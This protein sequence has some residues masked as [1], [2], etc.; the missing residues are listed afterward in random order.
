MFFFSPL[1]SMA[2]INIAAAVLPAIF[3]LRYIYRKDKI[4]KE[5][6]SLLRGCVISGLFAVAASI[7]L[8]MAGGYLL[9][10]AVEADDPLYLILFAFLVVGAVEEGTK[11]FFLKRRTWNNPN[12]DYVFDA[13]VYAAFVSLGFAA[14]EN[15]SYV[16]T[17]GISVAFSRAIFSIPG[18][19]SFSVFMGFYYGRAKL[20][21]ADGDFA[22]RKKNLVLA[23]VIPTLLHGFYDTCAMSGSTISTIIFLAF[24]VIMYIIVFRLVK[25]A[26]DHDMPLYRRWF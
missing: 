13:I 22:D 2:F 3:L 18:H 25:S 7:V 1:M 24:V 4:E 26:S 11:F 16:F 6:G 17:Y 12:F 15:V 9:G 5:P 8:E 21:E 19:F 23:F 20:A 14:L 10:L